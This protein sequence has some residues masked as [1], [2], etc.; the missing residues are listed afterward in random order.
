MN[1]RV[2]YNYK[3]LAEEVASLRVKAAEEVR[4]ENQ[5]MKF[6]V[7]MPNDKAKT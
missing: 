2:A 5:V 1:R 6:Y 3:V 4:R 7:L